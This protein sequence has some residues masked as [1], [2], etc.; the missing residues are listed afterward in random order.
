MNT[1]APSMAF[2]TG[3]DRSPHATR[4]ETAGNWLIEGG[5]ALR[6]AR[7]GYAELRQLSRKLG[8]PAMDDL[9]RKKLIEGGAIAVRAMLDE[10]E[11]FPR[12]EILWDVV[13]TLKLMGGAVA[14]ELTDTAGGCVR[15]LVAV[16]VAGSLPGITAKRILRRGLESSGFPEVREAA[17]SALLELG[18]TSALEL[19]R[20]ALDREEVDY[21]R[22]TLREALD[23][24]GGSAG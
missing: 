4:A 24:L 3:G 12:D 13:G 6:I 10:L 9:A 18:D 11:E 2:P 7:T 16:R 1:L 8:T 14:T 21:V 15:Q 20:G 22:D 17:A 23:E 5:V 19:L